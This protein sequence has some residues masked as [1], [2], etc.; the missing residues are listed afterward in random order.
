MTKIVYYLLL[1][2]INRKLTSIISSNYI[3]IF[4][5]LVSVLPR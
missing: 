3:N 4:D 1:Q 2:L 5:I